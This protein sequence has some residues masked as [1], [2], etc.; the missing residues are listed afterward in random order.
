M[1]YNVDHQFSKPFKLYLGQNAVHQ[2]ITNV[3]EDSKYCSR[4]MKSQFK[5]EL[6]MA[7]VRDHCH[8]TEKY[9]DFAQ[10]DCNINVSLNYKIPAVFNSL[11]SYFAH[12]IMQ[13]LGKFDFKLNVIPNRLEKYL[14][15][16]V[17]NKFAFIDSFHFLISSL[18]TSVQNFRENYFNHLIQ[19]F[20][21]EVL[22]L[23]K[24]KRFYPY[25]HMHDF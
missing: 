20:D 25:E 5:K 15:F 6:V 14:S 16:S 1:Y 9:K 12:L 10:S 8:I 3:L 4:V 22:D 19:E 23:V 13:E 21:S 17:D 7:K 24:Q 2:F 18:D 11:K